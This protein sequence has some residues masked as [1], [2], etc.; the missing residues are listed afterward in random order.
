M[1]LCFWYALFKAVL[2][3]VNKYICT[4]LYF[5]YAVVRTV[6][7]VHVVPYEHFLPIKDDLWCKLKLLVFWKGY[8]QLFSRSTTLWHLTTPGHWA[9]LENLCSSLPGETFSGFV[10]SQH[11]APRKKFCT[12]TA[13]S[14][15]HFTPWSSWAS[16][17]H[18]LCPEKFRL[19]Q[20]R[21]RTTDFSICI[22]TCYH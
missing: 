4:L 22:R 7:D 17:I 18:F 10:C 3:K 16:E 11:K 8:C 13:L 15:Y 9:T 20:C 14:G 12:D 21:I 19:G 1:L 2:Y 6:L 5:R